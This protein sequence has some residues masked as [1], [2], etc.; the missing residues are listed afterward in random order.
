MPKCR[1]L[2]SYTFDHRDFKNELKSMIE[3]FMIHEHK[4][5]KPLKVYVKNWLKLEEVVELEK[6]LRN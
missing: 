3:E 6:M 5:L 2:S 1:N 4:R